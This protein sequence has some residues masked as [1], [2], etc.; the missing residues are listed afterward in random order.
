M[1]RI[2]YYLVN[3]THKEFC[4]FNARIPLYEELKR[5]MGAWPKWAS[6]DTI[7]IK[8]EDESKAPDLWDNLT[9]NLNYRD[10]DYDEHACN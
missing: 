6:T 10:L 5:I 4:Y 1:S 3:H 2:Q 8:G 9:M 7:M